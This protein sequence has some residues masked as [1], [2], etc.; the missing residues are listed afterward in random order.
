M[1]RCGLQS[2]TGLR[3]SF[4]TCGNSNALDGS[5]DDTIYDNEMPEVADDHSRL[6]WRKYSA[7]SSTPNLGEIWPV[8]SLICCKN[9]SAYRRI[10]TVSC[11]RPCTSIR[12]NLHL[13]NNSLFARSVLRIQGPSRE[14]W[15]NKKR[16]RIIFFATS[17]AINNFHH[18]G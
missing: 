15:Y 17:S 14:T 8:L 18:I 2:L 6:F 12:L 4:K 10:N 7:I 5:Q 16:F 11:F 13:T 3:R 1:Q 9:R